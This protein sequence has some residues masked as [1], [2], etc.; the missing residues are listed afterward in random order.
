MKLAEQQQI[1]PIHKQKVDPKAYDAFLKGNFFLQQGIRGI[2]KS[3]DYFHQALS[4]D[5]SMTDAHV[6]LAEALAPT[7]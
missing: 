4:I 3:I 1:R 2:P 6:G 7:A 5:P